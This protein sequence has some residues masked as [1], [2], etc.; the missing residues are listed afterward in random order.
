MKYEAYQ[1]RADLMAHIRPYTEATLNAMRQPWLAELPAAR[2]LGAARTVFVSA[3][4]IPIP[5][6]NAP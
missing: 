6:H 2:R 3:Q 1:A 5:T 4:L